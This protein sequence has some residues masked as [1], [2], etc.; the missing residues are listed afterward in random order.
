MKLFKIFLDQKPPSTFTM[1]PDIALRHISTRIEHE[2]EKSRQKWNHSFHYNG[3]L[4][5]FPDF[6]VFNC[7]NC[8]YII[9]L[10]IAGQKKVMAFLIKVNMRDVEYVFIFTNGRESITS[11]AITP[12]FRI[13]IFYNDDA[14]HAKTL[15]WGPFHQVNVQGMECEAACPLDQI[16]YWRTARWRTLR[17][18]LWS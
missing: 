11:N 5:L 9:H 13:I 7:W 1:V 17:S 8:L 18:Y 10:R 3:V 6:E 14:N 2:T 15:L 12:S 16:I 4:L